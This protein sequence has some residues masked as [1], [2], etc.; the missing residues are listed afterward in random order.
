MN[1]MKSIK[2]VFALADIK[3]SPVTGMLWF[4][5]CEVSHLMPKWK[6][7]KPFSLHERQNSL[8]SV[9]KSLNFMNICDTLEKKI[10]RWKDNCISVFSMHFCVCVCGPL[11]NQLLHRTQRP[12][13]LCQ[14]DKCL[15]RDNRNT[16]MLQ[17]TAYEIWELSAQLFCTL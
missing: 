16:E 7:R 12:S 15:C 13:S 2:S 6:W 1:I 14:G 8:S 9:F 4:S 10:F 17:R 5:V 11:H 3:G